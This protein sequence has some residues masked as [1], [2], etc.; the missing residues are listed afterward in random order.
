MATFQIEANADGTLALLGAVD[1]TAITA[2]V[3][4]QSKLL[5]AAIPNSIRI[6]LQGVTHSDSTGVALLVAWAR[7]ARQQGKSICFIHL[8]VQM[9]A[10]VRVSGLEKLLPI[11]E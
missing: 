1:Y 6:D 4:E 7:Y 2:T 5:L 10:I 11:E 3:W 9:R 8:P